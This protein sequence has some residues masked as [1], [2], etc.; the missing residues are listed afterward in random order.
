MGCKSCGILVLSLVLSG[1]IGCSGGP[2]ITAP[3]PSAAV[4]PMPAPAVA[5]K[6][7]YAMPYAPPA[8]TSVTRDLRGMTFNL[9]VSTVLDGHNNW[10]FRKGMVVERIRSFTPDL[11]GT[12]EGLNGQ[13]KFLQKQLPEYS[14][15][16][17]GRSNG[18]QAHG[19]PASNRR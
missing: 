13:H 15:F 2:V 11:L 14:F 12:Q 6:P 4:A 3:P 10:E 8:V 9:R 18:T 5:A 17:C 1:L 16:G 19:S 7:I